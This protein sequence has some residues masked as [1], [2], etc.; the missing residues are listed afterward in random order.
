MDG[1]SMTCPI[2]L[3]DENFCF[4]GILNEPIPYEKFIKIKLHHYESLLHKSNFDPDIRKIIINLNYELMN[5]NLSM[6]KK[7]RLIENEQVNLLK[8]ISLKKLPCWLNNEFFF[9]SKQEYQESLASEIIFEKATSFSTYKLRNKEFW[10]ILI[11]DSL[12]MKNI[13][14]IKRDPD[15]LINC[16]L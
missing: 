2:I 9:I 14:L 6:E 8:I 7:L 10:K 4:D 1:R 3:N 5:K 12:L 15:W 11:Q 13:N 16:L